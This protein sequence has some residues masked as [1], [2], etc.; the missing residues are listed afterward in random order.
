MKIFIL[1]A[2]PTG[3]GAAHRL[4]NLDID[5]N[6]IYILENNRIGGLSAT[7]TDEVGFKWDLG[8]HVMFS[9]YDYF[10]NVINKHVPAWY[11]H[12]RNSSILFKE[13]D[14]L[15]FVPYPLQKNIHHLA[16]EDIKKCFET[17]PPMQSTQQEA[18]PRNFEEYIL[19]TMGLG[20]YEKFM[21]P[22]NRKVWS[23][24]PREMDFKWV[25]ERVAPP[26]YS[27]P[28]LE[29]NSSESESEACSSDS[30]ILDID[31]TQQMDSWGPNNKF[32][33]PCAGGTG[34]IWTSLASTVP[35]SWF[36]DKRVEI[37]SINPNNKTIQLK[38][39]DQ[40]V[41]TYTYDKLINT[42]PLNRLAGLLIDSSPSG[43]LIKEKINQLRF[44]R[45]H[46]VGL[47]LQG[48][49]PT[50][51]KNKNWIY[52]P[53]SDIPFYR[54]TIFSNYSPQNVPDPAKHWSLL[55]EAADDGK[56]T[57]TRQQ[58][59]DLALESLTHYKFI[60]GSQVISKFY[61]L[62]EQGYPIPTLNLENELT[63]IQN[64][65]EQHEIYSRGRFGGWKYE[66]SNQD[67][68]FMQGV[69]VVDRILYGSP[70]LTYYHPNFI[71][72]GGIG[73]YEPNKKPLICTYVIAHYN[74]DLKWL[75]EKNIAHQCHVYHKGNQTMVNT[76]VW[77]WE[78]LPNVGRETH[79]YLHYIIQHYESLPDIVVFLQGNL[80][81]HARFVFADDPRQYYYLTHKEDLCFPL[82]FDCVKWDR[83]NHHE[84]YAANLR[85]GNMKPA[86]GTLGEFWFKLFNTTHPPTL[87]H[88][89][90]ACFGVKRER[91]LARPKSFYQ[92]AIKFVDDH[93]N[94]ENGHYFERLWFSIFT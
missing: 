49:I 22:Y 34:A 53:G 8:G 19:Q 61:H 13:G 41:H 56:N 40:L 42:I 89:F 73:R 92:R 86:D 31:S 71:N 21:L 91:I 29:I 84:P 66:V 45:V 10:L 75:N 78:L 25:G 27:L 17:Q 44:N 1:G 48:T 79:T 70:E 93:V 39:P 15:R 90:C 6:Q 57:Y 81:D 14:L 55:C 3:L 83:I 46:I 12:Q 28:N 64:Y 35:P 80:T 33:Y 54:I 52:F 5:Y 20:L 26:S 24:E 60:T 72:R 43:K 87:V 4:N 63:I 50:H 58:L 65:L 51:L 74:E 62:I 69:E 82:R 68:S 77:R 2:G 18:T 94:P 36:L 38:L 9:H 76:N 59:F 23:V 85:N 30:V 47:G 37:I 88:T 11:A 7:I 16:P 32:Q 67:H